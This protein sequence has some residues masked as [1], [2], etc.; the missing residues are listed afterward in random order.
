MDLNKNI[1][2][3]GHVGLDCD[4]VYLAYHFAICAYFTYYGCKKW[5]N[6]TTQLCDFLLLYIIRK[7]IVVQVYNKQ[8]VMV[9]EQVRAL[10]WDGWPE[11]A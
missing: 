6:G 10:E 4:G 9:Q 11:K 1:V 8:L 3:E 5:S 2:L 7:C